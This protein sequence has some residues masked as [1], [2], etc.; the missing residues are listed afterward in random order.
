MYA[1][2]GIDADI[3]L[4]NR[5]LYLVFND[6]LDQQNVLSEQLSQARR[7]IVFFRWGPRV[8]T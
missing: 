7:H 4:Q 6:L 5:H 3:I 8:G 2:V 1:H